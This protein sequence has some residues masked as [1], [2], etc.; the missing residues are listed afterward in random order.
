MTHIPFFDYP[1]IFIND[2][3]TILDIVCDVGRRGAFIL[4]KDLLEFEERLAEFT[5]SK[6]AIGVANATDAMEMFLTASGIGPGDEVIICSHTMI[7]TAGAVHAVGATSIPVEVGSDHLMDPNSVKSAITTKT[8]ALMP[9]QLNG[10]TCNMD[11]IQEIADEYGLMLFEDAA[12]ALGSRY[13]GNCA[14]TFGVAGCIS[15]Y[16]AKVLGSLG[17]GGAI[18]CQDHNLYQRLLLLRNHGQTADGE[19]VLWGRNSRLDNL[20]AAILSYFLS[21]YPETISKRRE[22]ANVYHLRLSERPELN[23]PPGPDADPNHFDVYQNYEIQA[24]R[25]DELQAHL[26]KSGIGTIVQW[27]GRG[28]HMFKNL[29]FNRDLPQTDRLLGRALLLPMNM[30]L[31]VKDIHIVCDAVDEFYEE[32]I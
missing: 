19:I 11:R 26:S 23:L 24:E 7:A 5:G 30:F 22:L 21:K 18:L 20:Q 32:S 6:F 1:E 15:F 2:E 31:T 12:Q 4:Q 9:T 3:R 10:R 17:D 8:R 14:G 16:P 29:G 25:R 13:K 28:V 27:G